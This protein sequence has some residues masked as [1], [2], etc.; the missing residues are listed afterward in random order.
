[1]KLAIKILDNCLREYGSDSVFLEGE[2][3]RIITK[4]ETEKEF[5]NYIRKLGVE[6]I[7]TYEFSESTVAETYVKHEKGSDKSVVCIGLP[8]QYRE[9]RIIGVLDHEIGTH[10][11]RRYNNKFQPWH[12]KKKKFKMK[13]HVTTEEGLAAI[14]QM[15]HMVK[16]IDFNG[17]NFFLW[18]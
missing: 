1:M 8:I 5:S 12:K 6:D 14:N 3:G 15:F 11:I 10:F 13:P 7:L 17:R 9:G 4:E 18:N 16:K 2:Y